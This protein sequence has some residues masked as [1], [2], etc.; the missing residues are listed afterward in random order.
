M[1]TLT[2]SSSGESVATP[3]WE[4]CED[5]THT[6]KMGTWESSGTPKTSEFDCRGQKTLHYDVFHIIEKLL[7]CRCRKWARMNHLDICSTS[8]GKKK[9]RESRKVGSLTPD[10]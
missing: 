9:G 10:H 7:K 8:Y 4:E 5:E 6:P 2:F 3:L 1:K